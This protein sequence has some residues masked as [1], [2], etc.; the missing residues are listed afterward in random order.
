MHVADLCSWFR[1]LEV[2][3]LSCTAVQNL[4]STVALPSLRRLKL[5]DCE[6]LLSLPVELA[7]KCSSLIQLDVNGS[8]SLAFPPYTTAMKGV[9]AVTS[10]LSEAVKGSSL[11]LRVKLM[12]LGNGRAGKTSILRRLAGLSFDPL[13]ASTARV[14]SPSFAQQLQFSPS[15]SN[16]DAVT[17]SVWDFPGQLE[18]SA[19]HDHFISSRQAVIVLVWDSS[20][21]LV[22]QRAQLLYWLG[23][24]AA[25]PNP[26]MRVVIVGTKA[27]V[28]REQQDAVKSMASFVAFTFKS[29]LKIMQILFV[30]SKEPIMDGIDTVQSVRQ[31]IASSADD[32]FVQAGSSELRFPLHYF[33]LSVLLKKFAEKRK[34]TALPIIPIDCDQLKQFV[35]SH[36]GSEYF[37]S[38]CEALHDIGEIVYNR[39][40]RAICL[41]PEWLAA[42]VALFADPDKGI[43]PFPQLVEVAE[44]LLSNSKVSKCQSEEDANLLIGLLIQI[45]VIIRN[46]S[47]LMIPISLRG[48]PSS[49]TDVTRH[50]NAKVRGIR[51]ERV[52][53]G[54]ATAGAFLECMVSMRGSGSCWGNA[55]CFGD[56]GFVRCADDRFSVDVVAWSDTIDLDA[57]SSRI[58]SKCFGSKA[59]VLKKP[60]C[61]HCISSDVFVRI[62]VAHAF[63]SCQMSQ[64]LLHCSRHHSVAVA[65]FA[66][67]D[68]SLGGGLLAVNGLS[69]LQFL[70]WRRLSIS[71]IAMEPD[72]SGEIL[73]G[74]FFTQTHSSVRERRHLSPSDVLKLQ[75]AVACGLEK[76]SVRV[77]SKGV[78]KSSSAPSCLMSVDCLDN[79]VDLELTLNFREGDCIEYEHKLEIIYEIWVPSSSHASKFERVKSIGCR[80]RGFLIISPIISPENESKGQKKRKFVSLHGSG[81]GLCVASL[82]RSDVVRSSHAVRKVWSEAMEM[83]MLA[84]SERLIFDVEKIDLFS[85]PAN[86]Q[87]FKTYCDVVASIARAPVDK[88]PKWNAHQLQVLR[89]FERFEKRFRVGRS[90]DEKRV[91]GWWG[92]QTRVYQGIGANGFQELPSELKRDPGFFGSGFY[93]TQFPR[94]SDYY[95][96]SPHDSFKKTSGAILMCVIVLGRPYPVTEW[97]YEPKTLLGKK[98]GAGSPCGVLEPHHSHYAAVKSS[99]MKDEKGEESFKYLPA[100]FRAEAEFDEVV[101]FES[102]AILPLGI[103]SFRRRNHTL[104][105]LDDVPARNFD[106]LQHILTDADAHTILQGGPSTFSSVFK[107]SAAHEDNVNGELRLFESASDLISVL[108]QEW[109]WAS[110]PPSLLRIVTTRRQLPELAAFLAEDDVWKNEFPAVLVYYGGLSRDGLEVLQSRPH[111]WATADVSK[112]LT[113]VS[114]WPISTLHDIE[115]M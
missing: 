70:P 64:D 90:G 56:D 87:K 36:A 57:M 104:L 49:W 81:D 28:A 88:Q 20:L 8:C 6:S 53:V 21:D 74:S 30:S 72:G 24:L 1:F 55:F 79:S 97:P 105:W 35:C 114:F 83:W 37:S 39:K 80:Q 31:A 41:R 106:V 95:I 4:G 23:S 38:M 100:P 89:N 5:R 48:C 15:R 101:V 69:T 45:K 19:S 112:C 34:K 17:M 33:E 113:F 22:H 75:S 13:E 7:S 54:L 71:L 27:D 103:V 63:W 82:H 99:K 26:H 93:F 16:A 44:C 12:F 29:S 42:V 25:R 9:D 51:L 3:D 85:N 68:V 66:G 2:L 67:F 10:F 59:V 108:K 73:E 18:Y 52:G 98:C 110:Y 47:N 78:T 107:W 77:F 60:L 32:I 11:W 65:D 102:K 76:C 14:M 50:T 62:G 84:V 96:K 40:A 46:G 86:E 115:I 94:Y 109:S 58:A 91:I 111:S 92:N 61:P 43:S